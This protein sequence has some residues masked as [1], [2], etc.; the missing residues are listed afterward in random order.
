M[1]VTKKS[2]SA[3]VLDEI[4]RV[5]AT[6]LDIKAPVELDTELVSGLQLDSFASL[7]LAVALEDR[8][9][10]KLGEPV[11]GLATVGD[12]VRWVVRRIE[13]PPC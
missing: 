4:R 2:T 10:V 9:R 8:F 11:E 13:S 12:L 5:A 7:V 6:E 1:A 3:A